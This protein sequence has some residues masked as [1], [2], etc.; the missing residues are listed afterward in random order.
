MEE[1]G[2]LFLCAAIAQLQSLDII[3]SPFL[4]WYFYGI[5]I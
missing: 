2:I 5:A 1:A 4:T 3:F